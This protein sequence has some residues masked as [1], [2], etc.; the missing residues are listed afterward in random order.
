MMN[1][2][3]SSLVNKTFD[4]LYGG[5]TRGLEEYF[6]TYHPRYTLVVDRLL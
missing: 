1:Y 2:A 4:S 6:S 3:Q 5:N